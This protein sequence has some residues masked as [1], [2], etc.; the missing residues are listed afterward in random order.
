MWGTKV[1]KMVMDDGTPKGVR[2]VL[3]ERGIN[4]SRMNGDNMLSILANHEDFHNEKTLLEAYIES[5]GHKV[6][7]IPQFHCE[8]NPIERVWGPAKVY[9]RKHTNFTLPRLRQIVEPAL[10]SVSVDLIRMYFR[11]VADFCSCS[12]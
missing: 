2:M 3:E 9:T 12:T 10:D 8:L 5:R 6:L 4:T 7:Y 1:Q 11:K